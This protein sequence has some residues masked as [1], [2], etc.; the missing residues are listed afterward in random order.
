M[1]EIPAGGVASGEFGIHGQAKTSSGKV[2]ATDPVWS[3]DGIIVSA[4]IPPVDPNTVQQPVPAQP[5][6]G[7]LTAAP[8]TTTTSPSV[9][10]RLG[11]VAILALLSVLAIALN[12]RRLG[13]TPT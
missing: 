9:D 2:V 6:P 12:R 10:L 13:S 1:I 7:T 4:R 11:V 8:P 3:Y 5:V